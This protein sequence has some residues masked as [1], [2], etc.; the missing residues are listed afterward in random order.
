MPQRDRCA[1]HEALVSTG[2]IG[3]RNTRSGDVRGGK[4]LNRMR[5]SDLWPLSS[6]WSLCRIAK[7]VVEKS[8]SEKLA[9]EERATVLSTDTFVEHG[10]SPE[11][12]DRMKQQIAFIDEIDS[13]YFVQK[14]CVHLP[15]QKSYVEG[16]TIKRKWLRN[17]ESKTSA[18]MVGIRTQVAF[19]ADTMCFA[20][21][22][23]NS[24][25][26]KRLRAVHASKIQ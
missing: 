5:S 12:Q 22:G 15:E 23:S 10:L 25:Y 16:F 3:R 1:R 4:L 13:L 9:D 24:A 17:R 20:L 26:L 14:A 19:S 18:A 6:A 2:E 11:A 7:R 21:D 8:E